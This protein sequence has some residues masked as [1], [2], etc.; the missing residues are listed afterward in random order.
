[1]SNLAIN[2]NGKV[3][4]NLGSV[5]MIARSIKHPDTAQRFLTAYTA[6][7]SEA[8]N[9]LRALFQKME[10]K[11]CEARLV[12]FGLD[13][14][15][16][17]A[18]AKQPAKKKSVTSKFEKPSDHLP[19]DALITQVNITSDEIDA[20]LDQ[21][22]KVAVSLAKATESL[23]KAKVI[24]D[25]A[26]E[27]PTLAGTVT[28]E[29]ALVPDVVSPNT[30][31]EMKRIK[32]STKLLGRK[33]FFMP[34]GDTG[35]VIRVSRSEAP[36]DT[37]QGDIDVVT[38]EGDNGG[39][40]TVKK[41]RLMFEEGDTSVLFFT[42]PPP[43]KP[44]PSGLVK[45]EVCG[46]K[47]STHDEGYKKSKDG[48]DACDTC[49]EGAIVRITSELP[50]SEKGRGILDAE[51]VAML[52]TLVK[53]PKVKASAAPTTTPAPTKNKVPAH[54]EGTEKD[55]RKEKKAT[56]TMA[57][58]T[59]VTGGPGF[60]SLGIV[61][62]D[63]EIAKVLR[64]AVKHAKGA[65]VDKRVRKS[66]KLEVF[67]DI[68][69]SAWEEGMHTLLMRKYLAGCKEQGRATRPWTAAIKKMRAELVEA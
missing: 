53:A 62:S 40:I 43:V 64:M 6:A 58:P 47:Y 22:D 27:E 42:S 35:K 69:A 32:I 9:N 54:V 61:L 37:T 8:P 59:A 63:E 68:V 45:C 23:D 66:R 16:S 17:P 5:G 55:V 67:S 46:A 39:T 52:K 12:L 14:P 21:S 36:S 49:I 60:N 29:S 44:I 7:D 33:V 25:E 26:K 57:P 2:W 15:S 13:A 11:A 50:K 38:L 28:G 18:V 31:K 4:T 51:V 41:P 3:L 20:I 56:P 30:A 19:K 10:P 1:M 24:L 65:M 48:I 34:S